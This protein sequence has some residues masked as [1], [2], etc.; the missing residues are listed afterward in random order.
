MSDRFQAL[1]MQSSGAWAED[2]AGKYLSLALYQ[3]DYIVILKA[4]TLLWSRVTAMH[5]HGI[6]FEPGC[7]VPLFE[8]ELA[9]RRQTQRL[10]QPSSSLLAGNPL[11]QR[12]PP[13]SRGG[14]GRSS[15][16]RN[17]GAGRRG[18]GRPGGNLQE[19]QD[20]AREASA[21]S[22]LGTPLG[23][24]AAMI[25]LGGAG[26]GV[27]G[28]ADRGD[29]MDVFDFEA[30]LQGLLEVDLCELIETFADPGLA[31]ASESSTDIIEQDAPVGL[32]ES[33]SRAAEEEAAETGLATE[34]LGDQLPTGSVA[35]PDGTAA[36]SSAGPSMPEPVAE[37]QAAAPDTSA[38]TG[39]TEMG[40]VYQEGRAVMRIQRGKPK[41]SLSVKCYKHPQCTFLLSLRVAPSD[42]ELL[43]WCVAVLAPAP[44]A[45][46][47]EAKA[48]GRQH[49]RLA[50]EW[51]P[52]KGA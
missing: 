41:N 33:L 39:P 5:R 1:D 35:A 12:G 9:A 13:Q 26:E 14:R 23:E 30:E 32:M 48:L 31:G 47:E 16:G 38:P 15:T 37:P 42:A 50:D 17:R 4:G 19:D 25:A 2:L 10:S 28:D 8:R 21:R 24:E 44:G 6:L 36:S 52:K 18:R 11:L 45:S 51:R 3:L 43:Q 40:Y 27:E 22:D 7:R 20:L 34:G 49:V 29:E 46:N